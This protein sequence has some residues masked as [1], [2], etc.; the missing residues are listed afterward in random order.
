MVI[1]VISNVCCYEEIHTIVGLFKY[2]FNCLILGQ[3]TCF[4]KIHMYFPV[5]CKP[6][7]NNYFLAY[8]IFKFKIFISSIYTGKSK[9]YA[10]GDT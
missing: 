4:Y 8:C 10:F 2:K 1:S 6:S 5:F 7:D 3:R 9:Q